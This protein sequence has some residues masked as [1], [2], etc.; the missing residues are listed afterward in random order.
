VIQRGVGGDG[1][2]QV[3]EL[4]ACIGEADGAGGDGDGQGAAVGQRDGGLGEA[5]QQAAFW[6]ARGGRMPQS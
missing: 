6:R 3:G 4:V 1:G 5:A 2:G